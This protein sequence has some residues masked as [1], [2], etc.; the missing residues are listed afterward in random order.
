MFAIFGKGGYKYSNLGPTMS[1][2]VYVAPS[3]EFNQQNLELKTDKIQTS[4]TK[5]R[6]EESVYQNSV[7]FRD[8][9]NDKAYVNVSLSDENFTKLKKLFGDNAI[10]SVGDKN[11]LEGE[12]EEFVGGWYADIAYKRGYIRADSNQDGFLNIQER[13]NT[14]SFTLGYFATNKKTKEVFLYGDETYKKF[15]DIS[16]GYDEAKL[17]R[18]SSDSIETELNKMI[19]LDKDARGVI[20]F[21][22]LWEQGDFL[23]HFENILDKNLDKGCINDFRPS[24]EQLLGN[25]K[26]MNERL[27]KMMKEE[28]EKAGV[29]VKIIDSDA[30]AE[31][32]FKDIMENDKGAK[33]LENFKNRLEDEI[34]GKEHST[35]ETMS[36]SKSDKKNLEYNIKNN[37][38]FKDDVASIVQELEENINTM[39][40]FNTLTESS[41]LNV[42]A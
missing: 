40:K 9:L 13:K 4:P 1:A 27:K 26:E 3:V 33:A 24:F 39:Q 31:Q 19:K 8:P 25:L 23:A 15:V 16:N 35:K 11:L 17:D 14:N 37:S 22:Q 2:P 28:L 42:T 36:L 12:A 34:K 20:T 41:I 7:Y 18:Q 10:R 38:N 30:S 6:K 5:L 21:S 29:E 32:I